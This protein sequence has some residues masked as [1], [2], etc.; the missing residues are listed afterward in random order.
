MDMP[1]GEYSYI[2]VATPIECGIYEPIVMH[3]TET[4]SV[5]PKG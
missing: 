3:P 5:V 4:F 1:Y 2:P